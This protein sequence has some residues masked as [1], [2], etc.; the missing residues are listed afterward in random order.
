[1]QRAS[2]VES[3]DSDHGPPLSAP[4]CRRPD[5]YG[6]TG[7]YITQLNGSCCM[8]SRYPLAVLET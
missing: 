1:M 7:V 6:L 4:V 3:D 8:V 5:S 2:R